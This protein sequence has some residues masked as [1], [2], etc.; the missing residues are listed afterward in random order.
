MKSEL[1]CLAATTFGVIAVLLH[2]A[3]PNTIAIPSEGPI[4]TGHSRVIR[5]R[6]QDEPVQLRF[7]ASKFEVTP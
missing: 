3:P 4:A 2:L 6:L 7:V 1:I 5:S